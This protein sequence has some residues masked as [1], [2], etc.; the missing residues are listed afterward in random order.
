MTSRS[1]AFSDPTLTSHGTIG[2]ST[3]ADPDPIPSNRSNRD[4]MLLTDDF[5]A[6]CAEILTNPATRKDRGL[7]N[8]PALSSRVKKYN[9]LDRNKQ[10]DT[11]SHTMNKSTTRNHDNRFRTLNSRVESNTPEPNNKVGLMERIQNSRIERQKRYEAIGNRRRSISLNSSNAPSENMREYL[12]RREQAASAGRQ[13]P[14]RMSDIIREKMAAKNNTFSEGAARQPKPAKDTKTKP[15]SAL[16]KT[17][18]SSDGSTNSSNTTKSVT[19]EDERPS[20]LGDKAIIAQLRADFANARKEVE[21]LRATVS[22]LE[23]ENDDLKMALRCADQ[24]CFIRGKALMMAWGESERPGDWDGLGRQSYVYV[25]PRK[26][27]FR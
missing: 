2:A 13:T 20:I 25:T 26:G 8:D 18:I 24:E 6:N 17:S 27:R 1:R 9:S 7:A 5:T 12:A 10:F 22:E 4:S 23:A 14:V 16:R 15:R 21:G 3:F 19:W 11:R